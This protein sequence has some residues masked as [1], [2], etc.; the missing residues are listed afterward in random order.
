MRALS[1]AAVAGGIGWVIRWLR[2][3]LVEVRG[4]SMRPTLEPGDLAL[5]LRG[6]RARRGDVVV[7][8]HLARPGLELVKRVVVGP[9]GRAPDG[10]ELGADELWVE[11]DGRAGS[12]D[13]RQL[14]PVSGHDVRAR[15]VL[16]LWPPRRWGARLRA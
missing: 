16:V 5:A 13:S 3:T 2:P 8:E 15:V 10:R 4:E 6:T 7:V 12:T 9:G 14:G 11:G 1:L